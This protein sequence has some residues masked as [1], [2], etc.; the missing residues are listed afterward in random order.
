MRGRFLKFQALGCCALLVASTAGV[1]TISAQAAA[2]RTSSANEFDAPSGLA[3]G[4]G[5]LWVTNQ[6]GNSVTEIDPSSQSWVATLRARSYGFN[7]PMAITDSGPDL[8]VA[9]AAGTVSEFLASNGKLVRV[10][11]G[12][13][14]GFVDPVAITA[15]GSRILVLNAGRPTAATPVAG[16]MTEINAR[17][18]A[19]ERVVSGSSFAFND[20]AAFALSGPDVFIADEGGNAVTEVRVVNGALVRVVSQQG[21]SAPDGIAVSDGNV[22]V[23]DNASASATEFS[24]AT[25]DVVVTETDSDG[26]Y[27]FWKPLMVIASGGNVY[28]ASPLGTSPMVTSLSATTGTPAWYMCNTNGP[29]YFSLLSAF[30]VSGDDLWVASR[31]GANSKTPDAATGSLTELSTVTGDLIATVPAPPPGATTTT[32]TS[33]TTTT[34]P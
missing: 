6:S 7:Q 16:S 30:A 33:T 20:P 5:H 31:S 12:R 3:F 4:G 9:N 10:I 34:T 1:A 2:P 22:W 21:L 8:F 14:F 19:F 25:G 29:Y 27:G 18:G 28:V 17:T 26:A 13:Q 32:A 24:A 11:R 15:D 23:A